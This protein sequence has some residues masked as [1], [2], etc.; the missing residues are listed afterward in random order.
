MTRSLFEDPYV[1]LTLDEARGLVRYVRSRETYPSIEVMKASNA[2]IGKALAW[3]PRATLKLLLDL[4]DAPPRNDDE[5]ETAVGRALDGLLPAFKSHAMLMKTAVG[6]LQ[7]QRMSR[8]A[9]AERVFVFGTEAEAL[10]HLG[11][12]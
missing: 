5:F 6:R 1:S 3:A 10:A 7:A 8:R 9:G 11:V 4:R 12:K 2:A